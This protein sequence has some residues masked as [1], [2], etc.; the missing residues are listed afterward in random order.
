MLRPG[1]SI[2]DVPAFDGGPNPVS[3][4]AMGAVALYGLRAG[5]L[6]SI[7]RD[8]PQVARN[9]AAVLSDRVRQLMTL[10][11]DLSFKHV[12]NRVAKI[13]L[14]YAGDSSGSKPRLTQQEMAAMAGTAR[15]MIGRS[16]KSLEDE[17]AIKLDHQRVV[18]AD[19][20]TLED[21]AGV[22]P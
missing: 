5:D 16:L 20:E 8:H 1:D 3:A 17:G 19:R 15:E 12:I 7:L 21:L 22:L 14:E 9:L 2:N 18:I 11:E 6:D 4:Q 13:L 10:V